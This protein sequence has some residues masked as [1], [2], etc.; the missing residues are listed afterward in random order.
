[1]PIDSHDLDRLAILLDIDG[2]LLDIAPTPREVVVPP[3]LTETL[4]RVRDRL[5][6]ALALVSGRPITE[7][8]E[9]FAPCKF[10]AVGGHGAEFRPVA[11]GPVIAGR[12]APLDPEFRERLKQIAA[13]HPGVIVEDKGY[14]IAL[15]YRKVPKDG[16]RLI[17]DV[18]RAY[19][20]WADH[21]YEML[22]GKA[23]LEIKHANFN[24]GSGVRDL[25]TY[26]PFRGRAP[27]FIGDD[28][29]DEDAF[30]AMPEFKGEA[31]SVGRRLP[32]IRNHF[33]SP[34]DVRRWLGL[35]SDQQKAP[36]VTGT[37]Q[38]SAKS[39]AVRELPRSTHVMRYADCE[40]LH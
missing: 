39:A 1:V 25:M 10:V 38:S 5:G 27:I 9:F 32:H 35:L 17:H 33:N 13:F 15:H 3:G 21:S 40:K 37:A 16:V 36:I 22:F 14:S 6:G 28:L 18:K 20:S 24:K 4:V 2:T 29:T 31:M 34:A 8:D 12:A 26:S 7:I 19:A 23:V 30:D 11:D